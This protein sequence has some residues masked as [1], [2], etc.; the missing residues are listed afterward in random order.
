[1]TDKNPLQKEKDQSV[2]KEKKLRKKPGI[3][4]EESVG[5]PLLG[6]RRMRT[7][8]LTSFSSLALVEK[9]TISKGVGRTVKL[10]S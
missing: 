1:L 4:A 6:L 10:T 9:R 3:R 5:G 8:N 7:I 2:E